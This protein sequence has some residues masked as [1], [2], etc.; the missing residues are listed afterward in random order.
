MSDDTPFNVLIQQAVDLKYAQL[1][2]DRRKYDSNI[3]WYR[4]SLF[5]KEVR[6]GDVLCL[7]LGCNSFV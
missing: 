2:Q 4:D 3:K 1:A 5:A 7:Y 6:L